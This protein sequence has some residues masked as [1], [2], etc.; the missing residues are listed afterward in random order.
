MLTDLASCRVLVCDSRAHLTRSRPVHRTWQQAKGRYAEQQPLQSQT[1]VEPVDFAAMPYLKPHRP[2]PP[3]TAR[4]CMDV[5]T[6]WPGGVLFPVD[7]H[8]PPPPKL[9]ATER[10]PEDSSA[11]HAHRKPPER[12]ST[13]RARAVKADLKAKAARQRAKKAKAEGDK[14]AQSLAD[15]E[16]TKAAEEAAEARAAEAAAAT[17]AQSLAPPDFMWSTLCHYQERPKQRPSHRA[18]PSLT[19]PDGADRSAPLTRAAKTFAR[20]TIRHIASKEEEEATLEGAATLAPVAMSVA[21]VARSVAPVPVHVQPVVPVPVR[22]TPPPAPPKGGLDG[23]LRQLDVGPP[24]APRKPRIK[25]PT[26]KRPPPPLGR[27][28]D[29]RLR[30]APDGPNLL[31]KPRPGEYMLLARRGGIR[32]VVLVWNHTGQY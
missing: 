15:A 16:A 17:N 4:P 22:P 13:Y 1:M 18:A 25:A 10:E 2:P 31:A 23:L 7:A 32:C 9:R 26:Y 11:A 6:V 21:S 12:P 3:L 5:V 20:P 29:G 24:R 19:R 27:P 14:E 28:N 30:R 8:R